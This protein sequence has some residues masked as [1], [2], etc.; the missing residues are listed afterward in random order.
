MNAQ[1]LI[2]KDVTTVAAYDPFRAQLATLKDGNSKAVFDYRDPKGNKEARSHVYKLRQ[3]KAAVDKVRKAEKESSLAYGRLV[4]AQAKEIIGEIEEMIE[5]HEKPIREIEEEEAARIAKH[6]GD[7]AYIQNF[8]EPHFA[9]CCSADLDAYLAQLEE[10]TPTESFQEFMAEAVRVHKNAVE[11]ITK[12]RDNALAAEKEKAELERLRKEAAAREQAEREARI[13]A[14]AKAKADAEA[15][16][17]AEKREREIQEQQAKAKAEAERKE[18]DAAA[19]IAKAERE[20]QEAIARAESEKKAAAERAARAEEEAK[21]REL[22]ASENAR[23]QAE[24]AAAAE[25]RRIEAEQAK[26]R[27]EAEDEKARQEMRAASKAHQKRINNEILA[28]LVSTG[29]VTDEI[30]K[31]L[32]SRIAKGLIPHVSVYY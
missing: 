24:Q 27:Q 28:A 11:Y 31:E 19:A 25:R 5:V 21:R 1:E 23:I 12:S 20:K 18:R 22:Q 16:A 3:T 8:L 26:A 7:I 13:A 14:E 6:K 17:A 9:A 30:A 15:K 32:I 4:D 29:L 10:L 2:P